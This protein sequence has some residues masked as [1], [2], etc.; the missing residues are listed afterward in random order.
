MA[1]DG[2]RSA[3]CQTLCCGSARCRATGCQASCNVTAIGPLQLSAHLNGLPDWLSTCWMLSQ[4]V[5]PK[6]DRLPSPLVR[7]QSHRLMRQSPSCPAASLSPNTR[8][9]VLRF[10]RHPRVAQGVTGFH[11]GGVQTCVADRYRLLSRNLQASGFPLCPDP[12]RS[13]RGGRP[14]A[15]ACEGLRRSILP[16]RSFHSPFR[17]ECHPPQRGRR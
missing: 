7:L 15:R 9:P 12:E 8:C 4:P 16:I 2:A 10:L 17:V 13:D 14:P 3:C 5:R 11:L 1:P 6:P